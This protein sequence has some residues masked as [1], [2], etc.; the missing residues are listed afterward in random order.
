MQALPPDSSPGTHR[1][2]T[3]D[4]VQVVRLLSM[5]IPDRRLLPT[6]RSQAGGGPRLQH[7]SATHSTRPAR[8]YSV[9]YVIRGQVLLTLLPRVTSL[10]KFFH[11]SCEFPSTRP[12]SLSMDLCGDSRCPVTIIINLFY[13]CLV[14]GTAYTCTLLRSLEDYCFLVFHSWPRSPNSSASFLISVGCLALL[15]SPTA[16]CPDHVLFAAASAA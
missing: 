13:H 9:S 7:S 2:S 14:T 1:P 5:T 3:Q 8:W 16:R 10:P 15:W 4:V 12:P 11:R 6:S